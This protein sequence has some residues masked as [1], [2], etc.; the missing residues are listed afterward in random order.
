M[1]VAVDCFEGWRFDDHPGLVSALTS[2]E[3]GRLI[4]ALRA[5]EGL[6]LI[7]LGLDGRKE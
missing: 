2:D 6:A 5:D 1:P 7:R 4:F 3:F